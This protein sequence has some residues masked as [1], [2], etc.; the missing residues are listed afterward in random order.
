MDDSV[1]KK[2]IVCGDSWNAISTIHIEEWGGTHWS[3]LLAK[4]L[5]F[6]LLSF[7]Q[8]GA[9]NRAIVL[10]TLEAISYKPDLIIMGACSSN[11]RVEIIGDKFDDS[12]RSLKL[13]LKD[14]L[15][16]KINPVTGNTYDKPENFI[17]SLPITHIEDEKIQEVY[18][19]TFSNRFAYHV[20]IWCIQYAL[21]KLEVSM[22]P[23]IMYPTLMEGVC[24]KNS[25]YN[26]FC[27]F[28]NILTSF[29]HL[30]EWQKM[31]PIAVDPGYHT[32]PEYQ[33]VV[34]DAILDFI[35]ENN[36]LC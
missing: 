1:K 20:D 27:S 6:D 33:H 16:R 14:M 32:T 19:K 4:D 17:W 25:D 15:Y 31:A 21:R 28:K 9:S 7:A 29:N 13:G 36:I 34:K 8:Q 26:D 12:S 23:Y 2:L 3:E 24:F 5:N 10:Q 11:D 35:K 30:T 22:I 18:L